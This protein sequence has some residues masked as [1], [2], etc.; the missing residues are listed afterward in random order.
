MP[1][2]G[3]CNLRGAEIGCSG[4]LCRFTKLQLGS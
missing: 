4:D 1:A 2:T 3:A